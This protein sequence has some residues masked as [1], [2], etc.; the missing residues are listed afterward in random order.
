MKKIVLLPIV[1]LML[2][3]CQTP[4]PSYSPTYNYYDFS[5]CNGKPCG[6][7]SGTSSKPKTTP[8]VEKADD[9]TGGGRALK[10]GE[11]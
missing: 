7:T 8:P 11:W 9:F 3:G 2:V 10:P 5:S 6:T 4:P 1:S